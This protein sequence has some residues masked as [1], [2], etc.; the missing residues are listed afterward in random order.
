MKAKSRVTCLLCR[1]FN[2]TRIIDPS[3]RAP[4]RWVFLVVAVFCRYL[5][6]HLT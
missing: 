5:F 3:R 1:Y 2:V 6:L 4:E